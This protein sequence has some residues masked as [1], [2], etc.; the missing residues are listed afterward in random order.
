MKLSKGDQTLFVRDYYRKPDSVRFAWQGGSHDEV[1]IPTDYHQSEQALF[2][3]LN[4]ERRDWVAYIQN[5]VTSREQVTSLLALGQERGSEASDFYTMPDST[6]F[7]VYVKHYPA[8]YNVGERALFS[9]GYRGQNGFKFY[10]DDEGY[11]CYKSYTRE[12]YYNGVEQTIYTQT[13]RISGRPVSQPNDE[14]VMKFEG[15][16]TLTVI[17][18]GWGGKRVTTINLNDYG[19]SRIRFG[20]TRYLNDRVYSSGYRERR[21][22]EGLASDR[23]IDSI[24]QTD[25]QT[26]EPG[27]ATWRLIFRLKASQRWARK[28]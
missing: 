15:N 27:I 16:H 20:S 18:K 1:L 10:L 8:N 24:F 19:S 12:G 21:I 4:V 11:L 25:G 17:A 5:G 23:Q 3:E 22:T 2:T 14:I 26:W 28:P 9:T 13:P 6:D 7:T